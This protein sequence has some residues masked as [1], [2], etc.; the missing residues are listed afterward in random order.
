M[1]PYYDRLV[2]L[3]GDDV[4]ARAGVA[5]TL[6]YRARLR[7]ALGTTEED[8]GAVADCLQAARLYAEAAPT[9]D[10]ASGHARA[11]VSL[12]AI[13]GPQRRFQEAITH[14]TK[15]RPILDA[16]VAAQP[17]RADDR[18][19]LA[20]CLSN[21]ANCHRYLGEEIDKQGDTESAAR[22]Y[23]AAERAYADSIDHVQRLVEQGPRALRHREWLSRIWG[24][25]G[26]LHAVRSDKD[27]ALKHVAAGQAL[28]NAWQIAL[29]L[30]R[31]ARNATLVQDCLASACLNY[32]DYLKTDG[33]PAEAVAEFDRARLLYDQLNDR[34]PDQREFRWGQALARATLGM[35]HREMKST[36]PARTTLEVAARHY[37]L[38]VADYPKV[39]Q[40][41]AER[42]A[43]Y[44]E[45]A[46]LD[47]DSGPAG[48]AARQIV[49][50][51]R[52]RIEV[53]AAIARSE[54]AREE[55]RPALTQ[56]IQELARDSAL[57]VDQLV[58]LIVINKAPEARLR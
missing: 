38:L 10:N 15:A 1:L 52:V 33:R 41:A 16:L 12:G 3:Q 51:I 2:A 18:F 6:L 56:G 28:H 49:R 48:A 54:L 32:G 27:K 26:E 13:L 23:R 11:L 58:R 55:K 47:L 46:R 45:L 57:W 24:N 7:H 31:E 34:H 29:E 4:A 37:D 35:A 42:R 40:I 5:K 14:L 53:I 36:G 17:D 30:D 50:A 19:S 9:P 22:E 20:L 21:E 25:L 43:V 44:D 8:E 39:L